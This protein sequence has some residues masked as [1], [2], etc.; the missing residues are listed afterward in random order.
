[1]NDRIPTA[2]WRRRFSVIAEVAATA[3]ATLRWGYLAANAIALVSGS[4]Q[5]L[6]LKWVVDG[7]TTASVSLAVLGGALVC[8]TAAGGDGGGRA[9]KDLMVFF[10]HSGGHAVSVRT[11]RAVTKVPS[12]E[13]FERPEHNDQ[14]QLIAGQGLAVASTLTNGVS[15]I[16]TLLGLG[17][18]I[19]L[20]ASVDP[21]LALFPLF[22]V[23]SIWLIPRVHRVR[24]QA[25]EEAAEHERAALHL[26]A[27][28]TQDAAAME[29][30]VFGA[31]ADLDEEAD[32]RWQQAVATRIRGNR[33]ASLL[34]SLGLAVLAAGYVAALGVV[35][36]RAEGDI[37]AAGSAVMVI[38]LAGQLRYQLEGS[39]NLGQQYRNATEVLDRLVW[40][41]DYQPTGYVHQPDPVPA[42]DSLTQS[43][44]FEGVTFRYPG[45]DSDVLTG[46]DLELPS[47]AVV[48]LVGDNGAGKTTL[49][50]LLCGFYRPT[51]GRITIDGVDQADIDPAAWQ[52]RVS[53]AF[54]DYLKLEDQFRHSVVP[55]AT[56]S[57]VP[58]EAVRRAA[59]RGDALSF[60]QE[61]A[62]GFGTH[63]GKS[64]REGV[65]L[66]G[67]QWQ[68]V[69]VARA[70]HPSLPLVLILDEPTAALDPAAEHRL[71][72]QY[73]AAARAAREEN[74]CITVL[75]SHR[76]STVRMADRIVV[77]D[78]G[79]VLENGTH[80]E[81]MA[82]G[83]R[84]A[85]L[86]RQQAAAYG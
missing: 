21:L 53:G 40:L 24:T 49:I 78:E 76:F 14:V 72:E 86:F 29:M 68:R 71:Y 30:R 47:G 52:T 6:A 33:R 77:L 34:S 48:A 41:E 69:A 43:I 79:G 13:H 39:V 84:Y 75:I 27:L 54:Q 19:V 42:P 45:T 26:Q 50:K 57:E 66:S 65:Q 12:L 67:G 44:R 15:S 31:T 46:V 82:A 5:P 11:M 58:D 85:Q 1:M 59:E 62:E 55:V 23:P 18:S 70:M 73:S 37:T 36:W 83:G 81:L 35:A 64:Y 61:W 38:H 22:V 80:R 32:R 2:G 63:L 17:I 20:L 28:F 10:T 51:A 3:P 4:L 16:R 25:M 8:L 74:G 60:T 7:V 56:G 9:Q